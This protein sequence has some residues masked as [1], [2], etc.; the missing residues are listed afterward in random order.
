M[1]E[2]KLKSLQF[3]REREKGWRDFE[4]LVEAAERGGLGALTPHELARLP[5]LYRASLSA[6][7]V[8]RSISLDRDLESYLEALC[9]RAYLIMY[10]PRRNFL[11]AARHFLL[12]GF[13]RALREIW[14][15]LLVSTLIFALGVG[16]GYLETRRDPERYF[17]FMDRG[18]A[19]GR[20]PESTR[21]ELRKVLYNEKEDGEGAEDDDSGLLLFAAYLFRHNASIGLAA[22]ALGGLAGLPVFFLIFNNGSTL[23]AFVALHQEKDML[24]ELMGWLLPHGVTEIF[25]ILLCGAAGLHMAHAILFPGRRRR[26]DAL[27]E[28]GRRGGALA[29]GS[30]LL[31]VIAGLIEGIFRQRVQSDLVRYLVAGTSALFWLGYFLLAGRSER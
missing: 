2:F 12:A 20:G 19:Q 31:F 23:G 1:A 18:L 6:L 7:S 22:F 21:E 16:V 26:S 9:G 25:A 5:T 29:M 24:F 4:K 27:R 17:D 28:A 3:R 30:V 15:A 10:R 13:P 8:A 11:Q 14:R